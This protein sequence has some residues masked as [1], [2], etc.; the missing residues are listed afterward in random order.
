MSTSFKPNLEFKCPVEIAKEVIPVIER[1][2]RDD[3]D[4][5]AYRLA[6]S[7]WHLFERPILQ[8][9]V[10][11]R[12]LLQTEGPKKNIGSID[13]AIGS[14]IMGP[15]GWARLDPVETAALVSEIGQH[16]DTVVASWCKRNP[17]ELGKRK[18]VDRQTDD[19]SALNNMTSWLD[20]MRRDVEASNVH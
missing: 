8:T 10:G 4:G 6:V 7:F 3:G 18:V 14:E 5:E 15:L 9:Y 13:F 12:F 2:I 16:I 11:N 17:G 19:V 20:Q 1:L